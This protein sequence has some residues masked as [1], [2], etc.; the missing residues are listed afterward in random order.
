MQY[1]L[2]VRQVLDC[3]GPAALSKPG[4]SAEPLEMPR[5]VHVPV[6]FYSPYRKRERA[7]ALQD[8]GAMQHAARSPRHLRFSEAMGCPT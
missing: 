1:A 3:A 8:A 5:D 7:P 2:E 6:R 4:K